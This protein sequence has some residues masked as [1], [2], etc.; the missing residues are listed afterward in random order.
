VTRG[1]QFDAWDLQLRGGGLGGVR[2][3]TAV[4]EHG[5]GKQLMRLRC[6][7]RLTRLALALLGAFAALALVAAFDRA[8]TGLVVA[9]A[10]LLATVGAAALECARATGSVLEAFAEAGRRELAEAWRDV[11]GKASRNGRARVDRR[12]TVAAF[13][14]AP[15][16]ERARK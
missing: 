7:P 5:T 14:V 4:E 10:A 6:W 16:N 13:A 12:G 1:G 11:T 15:P 9:L 3:Q 2:I 8:T